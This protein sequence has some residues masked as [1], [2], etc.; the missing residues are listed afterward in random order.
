MKPKK[1]KK[2]KKKYE[3]KTSKIEYIH[4]IARAV[5]L[6][7]F[8]LFVCRFWKSLLRSG[9]KP[10]L[11]SPTFHLSPNMSETFSAVYI[12][13]YYELSDIVTFMYFI[14]IFLF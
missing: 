4:S 7:H 13:S 8:R 5:I 6:L 14:Y 3:K 10:H 9:D 12:H 2:K 1:K 11:F